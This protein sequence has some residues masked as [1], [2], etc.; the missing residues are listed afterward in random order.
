M[1]K[2]LKQM[3][4]FSGDRNRK[5]TLVSF[6]LPPPPTRHA[7]ALTP[8]WPEA[9]SLDLLQQQLGGSTFSPHSKRT[10]LKTRFTVFMKLKD[11]SMN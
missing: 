3:A 9:V 1:D 10:K 2:N 7:S 8:N 5:Y 6:L 4:K 11:L